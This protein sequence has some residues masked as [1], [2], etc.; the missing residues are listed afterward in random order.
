MTVETNTDRSNPVVTGKWVP[1]ARR[2]GEA[3]RWAR[4]PEMEGE[5]RDD[6]AAPPISPPPVWP[7]IFPGI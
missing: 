6:V 1:R 2:Q 4:A 7:R 5:T 3:A